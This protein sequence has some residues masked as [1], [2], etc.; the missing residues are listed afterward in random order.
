[1]DAGDPPVQALHRRPAILRRSRVLPDLCRRRPAGALTR[2]ARPPAHGPGRVT[3]AGAHPPAVRGPA[4]RGP[5]LIELVRLRTG[6]DARAARPAD[7]RSHRRR[8][9][10]PRRRARSPGAARVR[11]RLQGCPDPAATSGRPGHRPIDRHPHPR[12]DPAQ[13]PRHPDGPARSH[14]PAAA[15]R[16]NCRGQDRQAAPHM[17]RHTFVTTMLDAG[18]DLR[19]VQIAARHADPRTT[20]R[21]DR[22]A[23][24]STVTR[25]TPWPPTWHPAPDLPVVSPVHGAWED[26]RPCRK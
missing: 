11:Q 5:G 4:H 17:L 26:V 7:L 24:T 8:Y 22:A 20:M 14:T 12:A 19:D 15:A 6:G 25:T 16:R 21:Y 3:D 18:V 1:V 10:R 23:R 9:R 2:R 13:Q